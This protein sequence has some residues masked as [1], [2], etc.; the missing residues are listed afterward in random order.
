MNNSCDINDAQKKR[1]V[2]DPSEAIDIVGGKDIRVTK[3]KVGEKMVYTISYNQYAPPT[4]TINSAVR[5]VGTQV[6]GFEFRGEIILGSTAILNRTMTPDLGLDLSKPFNWVEP[7]FTGTSPGLWPRFNGSPRSITALD[8]DG[9]TVSKNVGVEFRNWFYMGY[10]EKATLTESEIKA[11]VNKDL[12][13]GILSKY[14][15]YTYTP[16]IEIGATTVFIYWAFPLDSSGFTAALEGPLPV[17]LYMEH[18]SISL[19]FPGVASP[20]PYRVIRT[21][22]K[23]YVNQTKIS[24]K[25]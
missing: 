7:D 15:S 11:L 23:S 4:I 24:L 9:T 6:S 5:A 14:S 21:S 17:P 8:S 2:V 25:P 12:L 18:P 16:P 19:T 20:I 1:I 10:S 13:T 22:V 3:N